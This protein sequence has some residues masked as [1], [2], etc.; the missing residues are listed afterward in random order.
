MKTET[1]FSSASMEWETPPGIFAV[2]NREFHFTLDVAASEKNHLCERYFTKET[3]GL[4]QSWQTDGAVWCNPPYGRDIIKWV[5][6]AHDEAQTG[7]VIVM[8]LHARTDTRWFHEYVY[9]FAKLVFLR[10][11]LKFGLNG[12]PGKVNAPF[13]SMI[14]VY[15]FKNAEDI[16]G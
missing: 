14:A 6:K 13:P 10:G 15:N 12:E 16:Y 2:L 3:D 4:S 5:R 9:P 11:R 8:L 7:Q 1:L